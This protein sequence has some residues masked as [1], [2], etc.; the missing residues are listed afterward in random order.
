MD[1]TLSAPGTEVYTAA[2]T[3]KEKWV[4]A[5]LEVT[6]TREWPFR[7]SGDN[8]A[9]VEQMRKELMSAH[10]AYVDYAAN[11]ISGGRLPETFHWVYDSVR[12][13]G[14]RIEYRG[15][16]DYGDY[17]LRLNVFVEDTQL[18]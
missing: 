12:N 1:T 6:E 13:P 11:R 15:Y 3:P 10:N 14:L 5:L 9:L 4:G 17:M 8:E 7:K 2:P 18:L 16:F